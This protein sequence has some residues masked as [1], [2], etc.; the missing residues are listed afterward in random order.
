M[1]NKELQQ[2]HPVFYRGAHTAPGTS[3]GHFFIIDGI[4]ASG[5]YHANFGHAS[6]TQDKY[7]SLNAVNQGSAAY[8]GNCYV[9]YHHQQAMI[10]D[11][12][13]CD[14]LTD[15]DFDPCALLINSPIIINSDPRAKIVSAKSSL[16][17]NF[18]IY[19][20]NEVS[21]KQQ[22]TLGFYQG[23]KLCAT[24]STIRTASLGAGYHTTIDRT[25]NLPTSLKSGQYTMSVVCRLDANSEWMRAWECAP[26]SIPVEVLSNGTFQLTMPD[27][28]NQECKLY[29]E[30]PITEPTDGKTGGKTFEF[31]VCN[32]STNNFEDSMR[33]EISTPTDTKTY[34][35]PTSVY[36]G[37]KVTYRLFVKN[38]DVNFNDDYTVKAYYRENI[39]HTWT[40]LLTQSTGISQHIASSSGPVSI[41]DITGTLLHKFESTRQNDQYS[42]YLRSLSPGI[43]IVSDHNGT[44]KFVKHS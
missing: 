44:R 39:T 13:P 29:L 42:S 6:S 9:C 25:F 35:M 1:L 27:Y 20:V 34:V 22:F 19:N 37:Q 15:N 4:N 31:T 24:S 36:D 38:S 43:Y 2:K 17:A 11:L 14:N 28:H 41:Y 16:Q 7:L 3:A 18:V 8:P 23:D 32:P 21:G 30:N 12:Y 5:L 40:E 26:N 10:T 33:L